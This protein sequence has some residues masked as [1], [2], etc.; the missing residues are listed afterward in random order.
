MLVQR[1]RDSRA[2]LRLMRK[3]FKKQGF[4]PKLLVT[5]KPLAQPRTRVATGFLLPHR[6]AI[7]LQP[8]T[9]PPNMFWPQRRLPADEF[10]FVPG[11]SSR[12]RR[13]RLRLN[14]H[15]HPPGLVKRDKEDAGPAAPNEQPTS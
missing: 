14:F 15:G 4:A 3:L 9:D 13:H 8:S 6:C 5:D 1:R 10:A 11:L 12:C 2:V 7:D